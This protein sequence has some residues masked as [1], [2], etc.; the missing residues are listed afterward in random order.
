M[1][2]ALYRNFV[3][4]SMP[5]VLPKAEESG[6]RALI[7]TEPDREQEYRP[8]AWDAACAGME[9]HIRRTFNCVKAEA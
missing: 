5:T 9:K 1:V 2:H 7:K 6:E 4:K 8:R 3:A